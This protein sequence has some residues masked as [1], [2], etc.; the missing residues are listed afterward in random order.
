MIY[1]KPQVEIVK[2]DTIGF[3][4]S[5]VGISLEDTLALFKGTATGNFSCPSIGSTYS[6]S[7]SVSINGYTFVHRGN[8]NSKNWYYCPTYNS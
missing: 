8:G 4:T 7:G 5:S 6:C 1:S 3:M 2:F